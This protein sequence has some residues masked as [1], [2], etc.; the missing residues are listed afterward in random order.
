M[1]AT[2]AVFV[3]VAPIIYYLVEKQTLLT[4]VP[5]AGDSISATSVSAKRMFSVVQTAPISPVVETRSVFVRELNEY[6]TKKLDEKTNIILK[7]Y[8]TKHAK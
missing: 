5:P 3:E 4:F 1:R 2:S 7:V 8:I 6:P